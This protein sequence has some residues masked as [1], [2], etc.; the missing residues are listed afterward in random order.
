MAARFDKHFVDEVRARTRLVDLVGRDVT[1]R[2]HGREYQGL[3]P[4]HNERT[5]SFTVNEEKGFYHC[6]GCGAHG[7]MFGWMEARFGLAFPEAV[8]E[9]AAQAGLEVPGAEAGGAARKE[10][11]PKPPVERPGRE[12][13]EAR[14][15]REREKVHG[16][17]RGAPRLKPGDPADFYLN[18]ARGLERGTY[19][20][21]A[22][23]RCHPDFPYWLPG[24]DAGPVLAGRF[25]AMFAAVQGPDGR[26]AALHITYLEPGGAGKLDVKARGFPDGAK[27]KKVRGRPWG[28]A[29]RLF[30]AG[31]RTA[32]AEGIETALSVAQGAGV[33]AWAVYSLGNF[34]GSGRG[35]GAIHPERPGKRLP[36]RIPDME[37]PGFVP[38]AGVAEALWCEDGDSGDAHAAAAQVAC[39]LARW[40]ALGLTALVARPGDG[41]DF[42]DVLRGAQEAR[43][44]EG[45]TGKGNHG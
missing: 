4:F 3:C 15:A 23:L 29:I 41:M 18:K 31:P 38:P 11:T 30:P 25:P 27:A 26:F 8:A 19:I 20:D 7:D 37:R 43:T 33:P 2:R 17:W 44:A 40:T 35:Q 10:L 12:E 16:F 13:E 45:R 21:C 28:G 24:K 42:N 1:L 36:S 22:A 34:A 6:F 14:A 39:G 5:P 9:L 32:F